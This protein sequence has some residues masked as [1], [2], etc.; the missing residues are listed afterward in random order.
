MFDI[1]LCHVL[2]AEKLKSMRMH[3]F[4]PGART[5]KPPPCIATPCAQGLIG[6]EWAICVYCVS[7]YAS[8][9]IYSIDFAV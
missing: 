6:L 7:V 3:A 2:S 5:S 9:E 4:L 8:I 1:F